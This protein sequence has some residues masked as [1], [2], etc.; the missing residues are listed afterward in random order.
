MIAKCSQVLNEMDLMARGKERDTNKFSD[1]LLNLLQS[2]VGS[3]DLLRMASKAEEVKEYWEQ[4]HRNDIM[5]TNKRRTAILEG[6]AEGSAGAENDIDDDN[7]SHNNRARKTNDE[8]YTGR[9]NMS[10]DTNDQSSSDLTAPNDQEDDEEADMSRIGSIQAELDALLW[11][12]QEEKELQSK[13]QEGYRM[14]KNPRSFKHQIFN[15]AGPKFEKMIEK[16]SQALNQMEAMALGKGRDSNKFSDKLLHLL[17]S[18][19]GSEDLPRM[20]SKVEEVK[21]YWEQRK[22]NDI[23][24]TNERR[25]AILD[26]LTADSAGAENDTDDDNLSHKNQA[27]K[28]YSEYN[29]TGSRA[30]ND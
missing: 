6:L 13:R 21:D 2:D 18:D 26:G 5:Y 25:T 20:A 7:P 14:L 10:L 11:D 30:K 15:E 29:L 12:N 27:R 8:E 3:E 4:R 17:Q 28:T 22:R 1:K 23:L 24:Y 16:C 19:V 9:E